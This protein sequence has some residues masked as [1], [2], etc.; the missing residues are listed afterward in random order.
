MVISDHNTKDHN[1]IPSVVCPYQHKSTFHLPFGSQGQLV[2]TFY[3]K[4]TKNLP[5]PLLQ[6]N[7]NKNLEFF[8]CHHKL[9]MGKFWLWLQSHASMIHTEAGDDFNSSY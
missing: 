6:K 4:Y 1:L 9:L 3:V 8:I 5:F 7:Y 2:F